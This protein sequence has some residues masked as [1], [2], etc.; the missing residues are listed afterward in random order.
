MQTLR[1]QLNEMGDTITDKQ[2]ASNLLDKFE[3]L[4]T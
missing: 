3:A 1:A 2:L 4:I